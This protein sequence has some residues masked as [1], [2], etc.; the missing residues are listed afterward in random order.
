[1]AVL[2]IAGDQLPTIPLVEVVGN[3]GI[4]VPLQ[5]GP[6]AAKVGVTLGV[7]VIVST[8]VVAH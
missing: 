7:I 8:A 4:D 1:V 3:A 6:T 2:L 5:N